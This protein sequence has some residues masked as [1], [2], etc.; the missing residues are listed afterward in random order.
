MDGISH[1]S[2]HEIIYVPLD[3]GLSLAG[4]LDPNTRLNLDEPK[5]TEKNPGFRTVLTSH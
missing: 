2:M 1:S 4:D 3:S 5:M